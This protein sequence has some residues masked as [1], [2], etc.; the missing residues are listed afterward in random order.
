MIK[1]ENLKATLGYIVEKRSGY[2]SDLV[3]FE[4]SIVDSFERVGFIKSGQTLRERTYS[5]TNLGDA[6]YRDLFGWR[7]YIVRRV[8]G[9]I[10]KNF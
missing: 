10:G 4:N 5:V 3:K 6:Y 1:L 8:K 2:K 7:N 9:F